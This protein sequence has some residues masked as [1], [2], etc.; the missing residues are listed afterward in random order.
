MG[1]PAKGCNTLGRFD[2]IRLPLPAARITTTILFCVMP[3]GPIE[4]ET[5][6]YQ[7]CSF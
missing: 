7:V 3:H 1:H 4:T 6:T 5:H 2:C